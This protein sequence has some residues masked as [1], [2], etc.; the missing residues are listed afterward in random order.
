MSAP[1]P[2]SLAAPALGVSVSAPAQ[3]SELADYAHFL[4]TLARENRLFCVKT[5]RVDLAAGLPVIPC[6]DHEAQLQG[7][8]APHISVYLEDAQGELHEIGLIAS[9]RRIVVDMPSTFAETSPEARDRMCRRLRELF[10]GKEVA[11][12]SLS[13]LRGD[14]RVAQVIR[15]QLRL[16]DV[17]CG[18]DGPALRWSLEKLRAISDLMEKESR[19]YSWGVRTMMPI[20][21][22]AGVATFLFIG[23]F[24]HSVATQTIEIL[25][26]GT[27]TVLT[28]GFLYFGLKAVYLTELGTRVWK[29]ATEYKLILDARRSASDRKC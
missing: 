8:P 24:R 25:R 4:D 16:R 18:E 20:I 11:L 27:V 14:R 12:K 23:M 6:L 2:S 10:P 15:A 1:A 3:L 17:L 9:H 21:G 13:F 28:A 29:R 5:F 26:S 7:D 22:G 19:V